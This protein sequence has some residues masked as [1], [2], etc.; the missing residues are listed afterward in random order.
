MLIRLTNCGF[1]FNAP[2]FDT[3]RHI[4]QCTYII[5]IIKVKRDNKHAW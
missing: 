2:K 4:K 3:I 5:I 1:S